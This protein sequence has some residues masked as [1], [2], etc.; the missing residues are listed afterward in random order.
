MRGKKSLIRCA[1]DKTMC[2]VF[3]L[4]SDYTNTTLRAHDMLLIPNAR[5]RTCRRKWPAPKRTSCDHRTFNRLAFQ[6]RAQNRLSERRLFE[7]QKAF[8]SQA[9][10]YRHADHHAKPFTVEEAASCYSI[11]SAAKHRSAAVSWHSFH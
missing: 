8:V 7:Y 6:R 4:F 5:S 1:L 2:K 9:R 3:A 11:G 10:L